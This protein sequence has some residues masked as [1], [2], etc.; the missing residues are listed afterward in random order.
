[1]LPPPVPKPP[2]L[3][4]LLPAPR[5][6]L[7]AHPRAHRARTPDH[8]TRR[9]GTTPTQIPFEK[10]KSTRTPEYHNYR[11]C[12]TFGLMTPWKRTTRSKLYPEKLLDTL[13]DCRKPHS[14]KKVFKWQFGKKTQKPC[15]RHI[16]STVVGVPP[17]TRQ[18]DFQRMQMKIKFPD[19]HFL[20]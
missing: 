6:P 1:M 19:M 9:V 18:T 4:S 10:Y 8:H 2:S 14:P 11:K 5:V 13:A 17:L 7:P 20:G 12:V 16:L 15:S 3:P